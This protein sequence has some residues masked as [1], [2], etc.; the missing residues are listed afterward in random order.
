MSLRDVHRNER[1][2]VEHIAKFA[3]TAKNQKV[4]E[5]GLRLLEMNRDESISSAIVTRSSEWKIASR[6]FAS[7]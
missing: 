5:A 6:H 2:H 7:L 4:R 3:A 1:A